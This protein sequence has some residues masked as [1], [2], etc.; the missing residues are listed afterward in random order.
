LHLLFSDGSLSGI[1]YDLAYFN[2]QEGR[3]KGTKTGNRLQVK[4]AVAEYADLLPSMRELKSEGLSLRAIANR[5]NTDRHTTR[6]GTAWS[7]VQVM[8]VL[9]RAE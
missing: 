6:T 3:V 9:H 4:Q 5:L 7:Q 1:N 2:L 8:R